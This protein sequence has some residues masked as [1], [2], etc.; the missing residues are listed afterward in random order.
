MM[1]KLNL[2]RG[3]AA[4][5]VAL[6]LMALAEPAAAQSGLGQTTGQPPLIIKGGWLFTGA[7]DKVVK[8]TGVLIVSGKI[9]AVNRPIDAVES[10]GARTITLRDDEYVLPGLI[11]MHAHYNMM[12]GPKPI[13]ADETQYNPLIFLANGVT[14][15]FPAGEYNPEEMKA[16]RERIESGQQIGPR[17]FNSGPYFGTARPGWDKNT[18]PEQ[19]YK[20][21]D[22]W[23][24]KGAK[25]FKAKGINP[26]QLRALIERA[27]QHG[28]KVTGHLGSG[29]NNGVNPRDAILMG[30]D[31]VEHFMG[32]DELDPAKGA[33][34]SWINIDVKSKEFKGIVNLFESR[35]V[36]YDATMTAYAYYG[37]DKNPNLEYWDDEIKYMTPEAQAYV[38]S[39]PLRTVP[40]MAAMY[41]AIQRTTKAF[42]DAG[43]TISMGTDHPSTGHYLSGFA[44]HRELAALAGAGIPNAAVLK[45][46]TTNSAK[47]LGV[48]DRLG[49]IE[50]GKLADMFII[51]GNPLVDIRNTRTVHTVIKSGVVYDSKELLSQAVGKIPM[52]PQRP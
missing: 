14:S 25:A 52:S 20:E 44:A 48:F 26:E 9:M 11:D 33:Y 46:A 47:A 43:G 32:G 22:E 23:V 1:R 28:L 38:R 2:R 39:H 29:D 8:N 13:R 27:H 40:T 51:T 7:S 15:T 4:V 24:L 5:A 16:L 19:I 18:T 10:A 50:P 21:V 3:L 35:N 45:I 6:G 30:I 12:V 41:W 31:R 49:T 37:P 42:Y 34:D 36:T 17:L